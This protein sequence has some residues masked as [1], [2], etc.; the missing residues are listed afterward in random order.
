MTKQELIEMEQAV[1]NLINKTP[2]QREALENA[3][4]DIMLL[5][6]RLR[7]AREEIEKLSI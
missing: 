1:D 6:E 4:K 5:R 7:I 2:A 3:Q